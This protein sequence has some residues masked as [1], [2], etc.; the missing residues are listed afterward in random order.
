MAAVIASQPANQTA[1]HAV[2]NSD[3]QPASLKT[4]K[5]SNRLTKPAVAWVKT[6]PHV[7]PP[8]AVAEIDRALAT[9]A[10]VLT[11]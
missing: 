8:S 10:A 3:K 4:V 5:Q 2:R 9:R 6:H 7:L 11:L 1:S